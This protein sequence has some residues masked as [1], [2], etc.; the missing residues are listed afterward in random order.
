MRR[1]RKFKLPVALRE[2]TADELRNWTLRYLDGTAPA[3]IKERLRSQELRDRWADE[4][5][6]LRDRYDDSL[7]QRHAEANLLRENNKT[8]LL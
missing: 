5:V 7:S 4:L 1:Q 8:D 2:V 3:P 6:A